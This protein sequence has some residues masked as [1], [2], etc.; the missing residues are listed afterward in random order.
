MSTR[1]LQPPP[2][3]PDDPG[4]WSGVLEVL[5]RRGGLPGRRRAEPPNGLMI[6]PPPRTALTLAGLETGSSVAGTGPVRVVTGAREPALRLATVP[7]GVTGVSRMVRRTWAV[8]GL[9]VS[10]EERPQE[11]PAGGLEA[12]ALIDDLAQGDLPANAVRSPDGAYAA[13]GVVEPPRYNGLAIVRVADRA[14][15]RFIRFARC[16]AWSED[17]EILVVG[18]EWGLLALR[19]HVPE[20]AGE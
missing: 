3:V 7:G 15:V 11:D 12:D 19:H 1:P 10:A 13:V 17:G 18:G 4:P 5:Q 2:V 14:V 9:S 16:G 20:P 6:S 8:P